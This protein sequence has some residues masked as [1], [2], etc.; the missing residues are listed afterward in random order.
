MPT[1]QFNVANLDVGQFVD[2]D[3]GVEQ[4]PRH[5][6]VLRVTDHLEERLHVVLGQQLGEFAL[7]L[8]SSKFVLFPDP[9]DDVA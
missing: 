4:E 8:R 9:L 2:S 7:A 5:N 6:F 3:R 1:L